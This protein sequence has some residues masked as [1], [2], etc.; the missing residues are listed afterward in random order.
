MET[1]D[2]RPRGAEAVVQTLIDCGVET[3]FG[4]CGHGNLPVLDAML[5]QDLEF[6]S[7][8]HEQVAVHAADAYYRATGRPGV[9]LTTVASGMLNTMSALADAMADSS[10]VVVLS[11]LPPSTYVGLSAYQ[12]LDFNGDDEQSLVSR[13]L[14]KR[15]MRVT[16]P[17]ALPSTIVRALE[18]ATMGCAGPVHVHVPLDYWYT[19]GDY[20][21]PKMTQS[22]RPALSESALADIV[23][24]IRASRRPVIYAGGGVLNAGAGEALRD[25]AEAINVPVV[26]SMRAQGVIAQD[27]P[28][29]FGFTGVVGTDTGNYAVRN[30]DLVIGLATRFDEMDTSSW[31]AERFINPQ[32]TKLVHIDIDPRRIGR[33]FPVEVGAV[34]D[35]R[36]ACVQLLDVFEESPLSHEAWLEDLNDRRGPWAERLVPSSVSSEMPPQPAAVLRQVQAAIP[37]ESVLIAGVGARHLI[38]Q[39]I[40]VLEGGSLFTASGCGTMGWETAAVLGAAVAER[41]SQRPVIGLLGDGAF[42]STVSALATAIAY[43]VD[44]V[45]LVMDNGGYQSIGQYQDRHFGRRFGTDFSYLS[46]KPHQIDYLSLA[47]SYGGDG[48][49]VTSLDEVGPAVKRALERGGCYLVHVPVHGQWKANGSGHWDVNDIMQG[50]TLRVPQ[51]WRP[52]DTSD[53]HE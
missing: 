37:K 31:S 2:S 19:R 42:N 40:Q 53:K 44:A 39:H 47:R 30:S 10:G 38:G 17:L 50:D 45:W 15:S 8:H 36:N 34:A 25:L 49:T 43:E 20:N 21:R 5:E 22:A 26:T 16:N 28:L 12:E 11:G 41:G 6:I 51:P 32:T 33:Y 27:H 1:T 23:G 3:V 9:V 46:G 24:L 7:V 52:L 14:V 29:E 35:A 4:M 18:E 13:P 48:E